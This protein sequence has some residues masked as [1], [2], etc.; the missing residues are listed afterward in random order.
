M[1]VVAFWAG[2]HKLACYL[3]RTAFVSI[4]IF[5][6]GHKPLSNKPLLNNQEVRVISGFRRSV[7]ETFVRRGVTQRRRVVTDVSGQC[8]SPIFKG[9]DDS[10]KIFRNVGN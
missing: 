6:S 8:I 3:R 4:I 1:Y 2:L 9:H 5:A 7:N 10:N